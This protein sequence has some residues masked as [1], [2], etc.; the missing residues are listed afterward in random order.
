MVSPLAIDVAR[1][2][3][4]TGG[5]FINDFYKSVP[6]LPF[7]GVKASGVGRELS[8]WALYEFANIKTVAVV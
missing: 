1:E 4:D 2:E 5:V 6:D 8:R 7:G 3:L